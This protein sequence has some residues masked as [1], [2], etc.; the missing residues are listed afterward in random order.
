[1][2]ITVEH[3]GIP[4]R[5]PKALVDWYVQTLGAKQLSFSGDG[6]PFF[7]EL[8]GMALEIYSAS[9]SVPQTSDNGVA[10]FRHLALR[11]ESIEAAR[12]ELQAKGVNFP[13][14]PKPAVGGGQI[15]FF[16]DPEGNLLH[17]VERPKGFVMA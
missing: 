11:V 8:P 12:A 6:P 13:D 2:R 15:Q 10:G 9:D 4:A 16:R 1:M 5:D 7:V 3:I 14:P 17:F